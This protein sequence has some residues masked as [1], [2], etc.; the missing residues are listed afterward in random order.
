MKNLVHWRVL[1]ERE[2]CTLI[3][4]VDAGPQVKHG[5]VFYVGENFRVVSVI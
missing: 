2:I 5:F 3:E 1:R 4:Y